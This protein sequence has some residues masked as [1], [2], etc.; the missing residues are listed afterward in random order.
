MVRILILTFLAVVLN[1]NEGS[2]KQDNEKSKQKLLKEEITVKIKGKEQKLTF[3]MSIPE[4]FTK[5][6]SIDKNSKY[7][8]VIVFPP[9]WL[10]G[11]NGGKELYTRYFKG[12]ISKRNYYGVYFDSTPYETDNSS[13]SLSPLGFGDEVIPVLLEHLTKIKKHF[14]DTKKVFIAGGSIGGMFTFEAFF[15]NPDRFIGALI[16]PGTTS[17]KPTDKLKKKPIYIIIGE[18]DFPQWRSRNDELANELKNVGADVKYEVLKD[19]THRLDLKPKVLLD[20][21]DEVIK[22]SEKEKSETESSH[23]KK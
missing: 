23:H 14:I 13:G 11:D 8:I 21:M 9:M 2:E 6:S 18:K 16:L 1:Q 22:K 4:L 17:S 15:S 7:P 10:I 3:R 5:P 19:Q 20:W 12:E